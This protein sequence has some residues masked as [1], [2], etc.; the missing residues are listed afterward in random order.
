MSAPELDP[1]S[2]SEPI[3]TRIESPAEFARLQTEWND[4]LQVCATRT[5][6]LTW[7]WISAWWTAYADEKEL[8]VLRVDAGGRLVGLAPFYRRRVRRL[9]GVWLRVLQPLGDGSY[10][11]E[12][13]DW[14]SEPGREE[15]VVRVVTDYLEAH[16]DDWEAILVN[17]IPETSPHLPWIRQAGAR[18]GWLPEEIPVPCA[19][20][21]L[22]ESWE[23]YLASLK[24]RMR[25]KVRSLLRE[26]DGSAGVAFD[27]CQDRE[28]LARRLESLFD[29]HNR[30]WRAQGL[31]GVF[32]D[33]S[34][35]AF[36]AAMSEQFLARDWLRFYS[37]S[38]GERYAAQQFCFE[39][40]GV[41][42]L[43]Q[44]GY[45]PALAGSEVGNALRAHVFRSCIERGIR[46][47]DFLG[48]VTAHKLAWGSSVH[49][50]FRIALSRPTLKNALLYHAA[51]AKKALLRPPAGRQEEA[52]P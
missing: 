52:A 38:I 31:P 24:P 44:E 10:D 30:R 3:A 28:N 49:R 18:H 23:V 45:D 33:S 41:L 22:P 19:R 11:S 32:E 43:L 1:A 48:G 20:A 7:E 42:H 36:Y 13:L 12:Y 17:E 47:Y 37:L 21:V 29:L 35:R 5:V 46:V 6:F 2:R 26:F 39:Y 9:P 16:G 27:W 25:T 51:R 4:L 15:Q 50:S 40:E 34:K 8:F 14:L